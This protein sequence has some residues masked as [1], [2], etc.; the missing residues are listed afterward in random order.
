MA[1]ECDKSLEA[2]EKKNKN[3]DARSMRPVEKD[4]AWDALRSQP[5][6]IAVLKKIGLE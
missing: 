5:R 4:P 1:A 2:V 6:F 3:R